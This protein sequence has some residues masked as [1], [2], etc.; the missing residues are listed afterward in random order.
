M[1]D[2]NGF[3]RCGL[4]CHMTVCEL[5]GQ[6]P[7]KKLTKK[8]K[9]R[10]EAEQAE[11]LRIEMEREKLKKVEEARHK[12]KVEREQAKRRL[13][14]EI[15]EN[16]ERRTQLK[17]SIAF[18]EQIQQTI[19][20]IRSVDNEQNDWEKYMRCNGLPNTNCPG[21]LR[22]YIHQW[23]SDIEKRKREAR[24][25]LL[26]TDERSLL[27]QD[28][29]AADLTKAT[30]RK[31]QGNAGDIYAART[32][33]VL[34]ILKEL[35]DSLKDKKKPSYI[36][37]DL[38]KLKTEIRV[39]LKDYLDD[40]TYKIM[41]HIER[42]MELDRLAVSK[43]VYT[44]EVFKNFLWTFSKDAQISLN[45][46]SRIG[47]QNQH[48]EI[49]FPIMEM[50]LSLPP[51]V[52]LYDSAL[53]G[54]WLN[55]DHLS[56]YCPSFTLK[57]PRPDNIN[58]LTQTKREWRKRKEI[59]QEMLA[60]FDK[61]V[62]LS[63]LEQYEVEKN[64]LEKE[65]RKDVDKL[66]LEYED[67]IN[68]LRRRAIGPEAYNLLDTDVNLRKYR[69]IGGVYCLDYLE[70]PRQDKQLNARSFIR[71]IVTPNKL[72]HK[73]YYQTYKPPPAPQPGVRRLPEEIETE[74]RMI[75][76]ALD[77]L[78]LVTVQLPESVIWFEPPIVCRWET[79]LETLESDLTEGIKK[80]TS[81]TSSGSQDGCTPL[82]STTTNPSPLKS[83][84]PRL[85]TSKLHK[86]SSQKS[87]RL[88]TKEVRDFDL[89]NIPENIDMLS[90][91]H[92]FV[93]PRLPSGFTIR[94]DKR[95]KGQEHKQKY[96]FK[97]KKLKKAKLPPRLLF[98]ARLD[99]TNNATFLPSVDNKTMVDDITVSQQQL[100][101]TRITKN[102]L[103]LD[104][105]REFFVQPHIRKVLKIQQQTLSL[106]LPTTSQRQLLPEVSTRKARDQANKLLSNTMDLRKEPLNKLTK[107]NNGGLQC[108]DSITGLMGNGNKGHEQNDSRH[109]VLPRQDAGLAKE[110]MFS[111]LIED[112]DRLCELQMPLQGELLQEI[113]ANLMENNFR[114]LHDANEVEE[115]IENNGKRTEPTTMVEALKSEQDFE[116]TDQLEQQQQQPS[117]TFAH[118][119]NIALI[120]E[121]DLSEG[122]NTYERENEQ[123]ENVLEY[124]D[125]SS[126]D[127]DEDD[128]DGEE[129]Y[130]NALVDNEAK[131]EEENFTQRSLEG[132]AEGSGPASV[133]DYLSKHSQSD[134]DSTSATIDGKKFKLTSPATFTHGKWSIRDVHDTK[135]NEDKLSIQFRTG[136]LGT[137]G[138]ALNRY[139][140]MPYQTWE[141]KPDFKNFDTIL[142]SF[143]ASLVSV[144]MTITEDGYSV[145]NF[146]GGSTESISEMVGKTLPLDVIKQILIQSG[147][148]I[149][150][151]ED[152]F[153]YTEG[154]CEKNYIMEMHLYACMSTLAL[155][156]NFSWSR[157]NLLAGS[158]T[159]VLLMRE[160]IEGKKMPNHSTLLV[161]PLKTAIIDC[162]EVSA[163]FNSLG[164]PGM[165]YY[166]DLYQLAKVHAH[167]SSWEKQ[168]RMNPV[169]R[170]NVTTLLMAIRPL[171]F[172]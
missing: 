144:D 168:H 67:E 47:D 6:P 146:Q 54:L 102:F 10:L 70:T 69:I 167:P 112:L 23:Q 103:D 134:S 80:A 123:K 118:Y 75:E 107:F 28:I 9:A 65:K 2:G 76:K 152:T 122:N 163:S 12:R 117:P 27:T 172:C 156:H 37:N 147:V 141:L 155:S 50:Q 90:L 89:H 126:T 40:F 41:S 86:R 149:F 57:K 153:C 100:H 74:M 53:R 154:S 25:W 8:E 145:N 43:H 21:D 39:F 61:E 127:D 20:A 46:K 19:D 64:I 95:V 14:L 94:L 81:H 1:D 148:D 171:S 66:Y 82:S 4:A 83:L 58:I 137:F 45:S 60:E 73:I 170:D 108:D 121:T 130:Y 111:Q 15:Q 34:G 119:S 59:L 49:D 32:K 125:S 106:S 133:Y 99:E 24:N 51:T 109:S 56:D 169:L 18:F 78:A 31:Q 44:S 160:L 87:S 98:L 165:E 104:E 92:D 101:I 93:I 139:S 17:E 35:D 143:T 96:I 42:D 38:E 52:S 166:A 30:L 164:I 116:L 128:Y 161:T 63:E 68:K 110:Y 77:K 157:W 142:F 158:R 120:R 85:P 140:N 62:P 79:R 26:R 5:M 16:R 22:K 72:S 33:E 91:L 84:S 55:Y 88:P 162:T 13:Q 105:P 97:R 136:R 138:F 129:W 115:K 135:F 29:G 151:E 114:C 48:N 71:I 159:A 7:K 124:A 36:Y 150:P 132:V 113:S 131:A 3:I 11:L